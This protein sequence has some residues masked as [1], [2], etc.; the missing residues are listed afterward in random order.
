MMSHRRLIPISWVFPPERFLD[1]SGGSERDIAR[2]PVGSQ[3]VLDRRD[4]GSKIR[5]CLPAQ[6]Y[7]APQNRLDSL[8]VECAVEL[9]DMGS[10]V[11]ECTDASPRFPKPPSCAFASGAA[12]QVTCACW[13]SS[14]LLLMK[15][16]CK[17]FV[18]TFTLLKSDSS[19]GI[20]LLRPDNGAVRRFPLVLLQ[21]VPAELVYREG[22]QAGVPATHWAL[23]MLDEGGG[24]FDRFGRL[25][26]SA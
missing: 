3:T 23:H 18:A 8:P 25:P 13:F 19:S 4:F 24:V 20:S 6:P 17:T 16:A 1:V 10:P 14:L 7:G 5:P 21:G 2:P 26:E 15:E 12:P 11:A 22:V 9:E